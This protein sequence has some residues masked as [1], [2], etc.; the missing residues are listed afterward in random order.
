MA[1]DLNLTHVRVTK[2]WKTQALQFHAY[3]NGSVE[4]KEASCPL[5]YDGDETSE[6]KPFDTYED[7]IK[8]CG[9][10]EYDGDGAEA[11]DYVAGDWIYA[12]EQ[13]PTKAEDNHGPVDSYR[14]DFHADG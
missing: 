7:A 11:W 10:Y 13:E 12:E 3:K 1:T 5:V 8:V 4:R 9:L 2:H 14:E 6:P